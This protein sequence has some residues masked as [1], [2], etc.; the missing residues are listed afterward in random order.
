[1]EQFAPDPFMAEIGAWG[2][3]WKETW[4]VGKLE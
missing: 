4:P 3:P 2:L 1:M